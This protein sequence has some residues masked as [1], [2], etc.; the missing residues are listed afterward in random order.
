MKSFVS[1]LLIAVATSIMFSG[2]KRCYSCLA[3]GENFDVPY[4][5]NQTINFTNDA[6]S[7]LSLT[8]YN[9]QELPPDEY[10]GRI[11]SGSYGACRGSSTTGLT[12]S[13]DSLVILINCSSGSGDDVE[14]FVGREVHVADGIIGISQGIASPKVSNSTVTKVANMTIRGIQYSNVYEYKNAS[15]SVNQCTNFVFSM[16]YGV[17]KFS[18]RRAGSDENWVLAN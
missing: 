4:Y 8:C 7:V 14:Q 12:D 18:I 3:S 15:A 6:D 2:C 17:L 16:N 13:R 9:H 11:G 5:L 1:I 10:C